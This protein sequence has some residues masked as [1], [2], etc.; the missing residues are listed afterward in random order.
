MND[1][2]FW[3]ND[4]F[5]TGY[6]VASPGN[7]NLPVNTVPGASVTGRQNYIIDQV[8]YTDGRNVESNCAAITF[9]NNAPA[10]GGSTMTIIGIKLPPGWGMSIEANQ[11]EMDTTKYMVVF[12]NTGINACLVIRKNYIG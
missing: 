5:N 12:D 11:N 2:R 4:S 8:E 1:P 6:P 3:P 10:T 9:Y 7:S